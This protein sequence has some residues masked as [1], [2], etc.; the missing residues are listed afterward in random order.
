MFGYSVGKSK[1]NG[2][3]VLD[4]SVSYQYLADMLNHIYDDTIEPDIVSQMIDEYGAYALLFNGIK[5]L[6]EEK[7]N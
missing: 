6:Y 7:F 4:I 1:N 5:E 2:N 3:S